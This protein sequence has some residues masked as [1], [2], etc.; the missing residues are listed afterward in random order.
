MT[1]ETF[2]LKTAPQFDVHKW[3]DFPEVGNAVNG[4]F[5]EIKALRTSKGIRIREADKVKKH[6]R[7][8]L[9]DLWAAHT[10]SPNPYRAISRNKSAYQIES[11][12][13][14]IFITYNYFFI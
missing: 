6:L 11:R 9:I 4:I 5:E 13:R 10:F 2:F 7:V 1:L 8:V 12:Y 3:S 14:R